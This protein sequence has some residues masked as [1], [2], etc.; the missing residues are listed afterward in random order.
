MRRPADEAM[1]SASAWPLPLCCQAASSWG[2]QCFL[3]LLHCLL[4]IK[5]P[6]QNI[7]G[8]DNLFVKYIFLIRNERASLKTPCPKAALLITFEMVFFRPTR[9]TKPDKRNIAGNHDG[10]PC[11]KLLITVRMMKRGYLTPCIKPRY[12]NKV[13]VP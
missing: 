6:Q 10:E 13:F 3:S 9:R 2:K 1:N 7:R 5:K 8:T 11:S 4:N 12:L